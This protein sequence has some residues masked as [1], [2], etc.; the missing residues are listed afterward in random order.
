MNCFCGP[1]FLILCSSLLCTD[2]LHRTFIV[3]LSWNDTK[4]DEKRSTY[5]VKLVFISLIYVGRT[6]AV[7]DCDSRTTQFS[8]HSINGGWLSPNVDSQSGCCAS[9]TFTPS[10]PSTAQHV[11]CPH[12]AHPSGTI[13]SRSGSHDI[14]SV[15]WRLD[16]FSVF[17][18]IYVRAHIRSFIIMF[19]GK[20]EVVHVFRST[21]KCP[22]VSVTHP[23]QAANI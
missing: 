14:E 15:W 8:T 22:Y 19:T 17:I 20:A 16:H 13:A 5:N 1:M 4:V 10:V 6:A 3:C 9:W 21:S 7:T 12:L 11:S 18:H 23:S 2:K